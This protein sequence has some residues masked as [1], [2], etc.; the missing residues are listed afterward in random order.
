MDGWS[1]LKFFLVERDAGQGVT[2][3]TWKGISR[4]A[5]VSLLFGFCCR[6]SDYQLRDV[7]LPSHRFVFLNRFIA[8][9]GRGCTWAGSK[10]HRSEERRRQKNR[11]RV[12]DGS[13][14]RRR[15]QSQGLVSFGRSS[16]VSS[17]ERVWGPY[18]KCLYSASQSPWTRSE[19]GAKCCSEES[20]QQSVVTKPGLSFTDA[21]EPYGASE[22]ESQPLQSI[23]V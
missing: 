20:S 6:A 15:K 9:V 5:R 8:M 13:F 21:L 22:A 3:L 23:T 18:L 14:K 19:K 1:S 11:A 4:G 10:S 12:C 16:L 17:R 2:C 7:G